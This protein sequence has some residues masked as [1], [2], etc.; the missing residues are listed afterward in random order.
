M[1]PATMGVRM[2]RPSNIVSRFRYDFGMLSDSSSA[3]Q[4]FAEY[5]TQAGSENMLLYVTYCFQ[6]Y[7]LYS[8]DFYMPPIEPR[9]LQSNCIPVLSY[10][11]RHLMVSATHNRCP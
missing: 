11:F 10:I 2:V 7:Y 8:V 3:V 6:E 4:A 9:S 5:F 1:V